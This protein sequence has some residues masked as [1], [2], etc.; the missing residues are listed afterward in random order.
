MKLSHL[1]ILPLACYGALIAYACYAAMVVGHWPY[2]SHPDPKQLPGRPLV[3]VFAF[4]TMLGL[5]SVV[6]L[7]AAYGA[8][9]A[10]AASKEWKLPAQIKPVLLYSMGAAIWVL[11]VAAE[12]NDLPWPSLMSWI[13]D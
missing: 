13:F 5:L 4:I 8:Y 12:F 2:Y 3:G 6:V 11:D 7:P 10:I 1:S 9:R